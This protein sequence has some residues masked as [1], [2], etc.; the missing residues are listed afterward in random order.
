M[1]N[2]LQILEVRHGRWPGWLEFQ[3]RVRWSNEKV[4]DIPFSYNPKD[5]E[6]LSVGLREKIIPNLDPATILPAL[7]KSVG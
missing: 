6:P 2:V 4:E 5:E 7:E 3:L 1:M